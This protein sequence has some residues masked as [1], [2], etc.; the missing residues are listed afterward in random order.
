MAHEGSSS[1]WHPGRRRG[2]SAQLFLDLSPPEGLVAADQVGDDEGDRR[3]PAALQDRHRVV[4]HRD[5]AVVERD[6]DRALRERRIIQDRRG[7]LVRGNRVCFGSDHLDVPGEEIRQW[8]S[9]VR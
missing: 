1:Y 2:S 5:V 8:H 9:V 4:Q 6:Q 3:D 7:H